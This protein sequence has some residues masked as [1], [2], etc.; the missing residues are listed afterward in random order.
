MLSKELDIDNDDEINLEVEG[1]T[2]SEE[3]STEMSESESESETSAVACWWVGRRTMGNDACRE[4]IPP[5][6]A[7]RQS[8]RQEGTWD[9]KTYRETILEKFCAR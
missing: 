2:A 7:I 4:M 3:S 8:K 5:N 6:K 1:E 9:D